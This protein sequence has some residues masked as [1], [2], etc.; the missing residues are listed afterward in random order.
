MIGARK[1]I[2]KCKNF[3]TDY[4]IFF[5]FLCL[6]SG[7]VTALNGTYSNWQTPSVL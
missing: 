3:K 2:A 6:V 1:K 4:K 7:F 5:F